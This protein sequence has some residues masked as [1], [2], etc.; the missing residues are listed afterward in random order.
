MQGP[1]GTIWA[2]DRLGNRVAVIGPGT[3]ARE[4][5]LPAA[6]SNAG[7]II[8][9]PN[10][11]WV[12]E[13]RVS[14]IVRFAIDGS[15]TEFQLETPQWYMLRAIKG[16]DDRIWFTDGWNVSAI[17]ES[18]KVTRYGT[19]LGVITD[20][21]VAG[22]GRLWVVG[23]TSAHGKDGPFASVMEGPNQW[24]EIALTF[25]P[26]RT[27]S[28]EEWLLDCRKPIVAVILKCG[29]FGGTGPCPCA[30]NRPKVIC[31]RQYR[32]RLADRSTWQYACHGQP[33]WFAHGLVCRQRARRNIGYQS[34]AWRERLDC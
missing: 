30:T 12:V 3:R 19:H 25:A 31:G 18:G 15:R 28:H 5:D 23:S 29:R 1:Q 20:L 11:V 24:R 32:S 9:T 2:L 6:Y 17:D 14:K 16:P 21:A 8:G 33:E 4:Y 13:R 27:L 7:D 22:D 26:E 34:V 10:F